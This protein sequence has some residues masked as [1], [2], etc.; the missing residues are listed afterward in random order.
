MHHLVRAAA[1][2]PPVQHSNAT[3]QKR[4]AGPHARFDIV[5]HWLRTH[6]Q[7]PELLSFRDIEAQATVSVAGGSDTY[8]KDS[9]KLPYLEAC[10]YEA[11]RMFRS[12]PFRFPLVAPKGGI[13]IRSVIS[14]RESFCP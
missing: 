6:Q 9:L 5:A 3:L 2:E 13:T 11:L 12:E 4:R 1:Y 10:V 14:R 7:S 8:L